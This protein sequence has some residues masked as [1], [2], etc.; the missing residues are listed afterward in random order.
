M[1]LVEDIKSNQVLL[2]VIS[3]KDYTEMLL[4]VIKAVEKSSDKVCYVT[5]NRPYNNIL[6]QLKNNK[7]NLGKFLFVDAITSTV[8]T[9]EQVENCIFVASPDALTDLSLA[10]SQALS[11]C[12]IAL[13]DTMST[14]VIYQD[15]GSVLKFI[16][17]IVTKLRVGNKKGVLIALKEDS[18]ELI[19]DLH[20]FV[21]KVV[22]LTI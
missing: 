10:F 4:D 11:K 18:E 20:M 6:L 1:S 16:H 12:D 9:P 8:Q 3:K 2:F 15:I 7:V 17:N 14:L 21:D 13:F 19:K 22:D 5:I